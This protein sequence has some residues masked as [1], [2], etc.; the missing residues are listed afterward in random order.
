MLREDVLRLLDDWRSNPQSGHA[1]IT[2]V[3]LAEWIQL[4]GGLVARLGQPV[5]ATVEAARVPWWR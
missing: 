1:A 2:A 3:T 4:L 5:A